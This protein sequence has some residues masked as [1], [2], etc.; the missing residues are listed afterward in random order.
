MD[1]VAIGT[2]QSPLVDRASAPKQGNEGAPEAWLVIHERFAAGVDGLAPGEEVFVLTWLHESSREVLR[3]HPRSDPNIP[4]QGVFN[5][6]SP[7]RPNPI[8]LHRVRIVA[9]DGLRLLVRNL[10]ALNETPIVDIKPVIN[11]DQRPV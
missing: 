8:G 6:R 3:V 9:I 11:A 7:E 5:T 10:E 2:V 1:L 4:E